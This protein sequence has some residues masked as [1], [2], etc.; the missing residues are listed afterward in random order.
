MDTAPANAPLPAARGTASESAVAPAPPEAEP[1]S[2]TRAEADF[3][4]FLTL[5]TTQ[6]KNQDPLQPIDST[7]FVAQLASFSS[8]EQLIGVNER[9]DSLLAE[10][11]RTDLA[12]HAGWLGAHVTTGDGAVTTTGAPVA[13]EVAPLVTADSALARV[14]RA[15]GTLLAEFAVPPAGGP[16]RWDGT[17]DDG[18]AIAGEP[19]RIGVRYF[20]GGEVIEDRPARIPREVTGLR[21]V[22]G[23][24][25]LELA[26]GG[27][28]RP[29]DVL[30]L[31]TAARDDGEAG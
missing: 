27:T 7:E 28:A 6:M 5:L 11:D 1:E 31:S 24:V 4:D 21:A 13:F 19:V 17:G 22:E 8:V 18:A 2:G 15:D 20:S 30:A 14:T 23:G 26:D 10:G 3:Q 12:D 9:L 16:A 29:A 25:A